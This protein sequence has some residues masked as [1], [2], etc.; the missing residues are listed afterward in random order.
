MND[1][2]TTPP[3]DFK[4]YRFD[5]TWEGDGRISDS[6]NKPLWRYQSVGRKSR[7]SFYGF[8]RLP[9]FVVQDLEGRELLSFTRIKGFPSA[10]YQINEGD[11]LIGTIQLRGFLSNKFFLEFASGLRCSF[12]MPLFTVLFKGSSETGGQIL[13]RLWQHRVWF[14]R[15]DS[16]INNFHLVA[17]MAFIHRE[18]LRRG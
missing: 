3:A 11:R 13:V 1:G 6:E 7:G 2:Q 9:V 4:D 18:R 15:L 10:I 12:H 16:I 17:A 5:A 8:F 14:V